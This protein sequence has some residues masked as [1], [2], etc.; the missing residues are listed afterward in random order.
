M[1]HG[2]LKVKVSNCFPPSLTLLQPIING[3]C[4]WG[5]ELHLVGIEK[6]F[7][8]SSPNRIKQQPSILRLW[9]RRK[10]LLFRY[11]NEIAKTFIILLLLLVPPSVTKKN[12][13]TG[14]SWNHFLRP[15]D[16]V[17]WQP[18]PPVFEP[19][20]PPV[21]TGKKTHEGRQGGRHEVGHG[22]RHG[23]GQGGQGPVGSGV[24]SPVGPGSGGRGVRWVWGSG[25]AA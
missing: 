22:G 8:A 16:Y 11:R 15:P 6:V 14:C 9:R 5:A 20:G 10:W 4:N 2:G 23:C 18:L 13:G 17:F 19:L 7:Q 21:S 25:R 12:T 1:I 24:R 3:F